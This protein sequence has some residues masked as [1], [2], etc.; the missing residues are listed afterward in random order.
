VP[1]RGINIIGK[2]EI[3]KIH[4]VNPKPTDPF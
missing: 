2:S 3:I 1:K 4:H